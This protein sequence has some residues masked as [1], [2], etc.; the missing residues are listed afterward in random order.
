MVVNHHPL[1]N[2][3]T[4][5]IIELNILEC[6]LVE[7]FGDL[8]QNRRQALTGPLERGGEGGLARTALR[9]CGQMYLLPDSQAECRALQLEGLPFHVLGSHQ[10]YESLSFPG[11]F[12]LKSLLSACTCSILEVSLEPR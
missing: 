2:T 9:A 10:R 4:K 5:Y 7:C 1:T 6:S 8:F 11:L 3:E 12:F